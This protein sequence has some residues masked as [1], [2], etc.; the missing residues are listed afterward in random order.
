MDVMS[1]PE[2]VRSMPGGIPGSELAVIPRAGHGS[3][4]ENFDEF[5]RKKTE[6]P[7]KLE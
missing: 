1:S 4:L 2:V 7:E 6:F 5:T 3:N